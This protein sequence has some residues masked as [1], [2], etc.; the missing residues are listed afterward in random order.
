[1]GKNDAGEKEPLYILAALVLLAGPFYL[2]DFSSIY[3]T[4]WR[5]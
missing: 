2:N 5:W 4:D 1:M 3:V